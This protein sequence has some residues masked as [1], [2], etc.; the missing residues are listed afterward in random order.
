MRAGDS[1]GTRAAVLSFGRRLRADDPAAAYR[2]PDR[3]Y[4]ARRRLR[5]AVPDRLRVSRYTRLCENGRRVPARQFPVCRRT[6]RDAAARRNAAD[7][8]SLRRRVFR[9][10]HP[11]AARRH[12][13]VL[14]AHSIV[15]A[16]V[17]RTDAALASR[18]A[19]AD[20][21]RRKRAGA[22]AVRHG[23]SAV[24]SVFR[25]TSSAAAHG[26]GAAAR[27]GGGARFSEKQGC[28][29]KRRGGM[30]KQS[31]SVPLPIHRRK[32]AAARVSLRQRTDRLSERQSGTS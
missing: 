18:F 22:R 13:A 9:R 3:P 32:R 6:V 5:A 26:T 12:G 11:D 15:S 2:R 21:G 8:L 30:E 7:R 25:Q 10:A 4:F 29:G 19:H 27:A 1:P 23:A 17:R 24:R 28:A 31:P 16:A 14:R 20:T